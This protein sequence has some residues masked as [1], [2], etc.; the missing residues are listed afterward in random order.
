MSSLRKIER[1]Y[2]AA[3]LATVTALLDRLTDEDVMMR[4]NLEARRD[5]LRRELEAFGDLHEPAASAALFFGGRPVAGALGIESEFG[6]NAVAMFQD[7]VSKIFAQHEPGGLGQRGVVANKAATRLHITNVVRGSFGFLLEEIDPQG[8]LVDTPLREAVEDASK[9][10]GAF[11]EDDEERFQAEVE[12]ADPRVLNTAR[13][14][15]EL[16]RDDEATFK[17]VVGHSEK[18]FN[19][20][21]VAR[22]SERAVGT[23]VEDEEEFLSGTLAGVLPEGHMFEFRSDGPR[24]VIRGKVDKCIPA[25]ELAEY[26]HRWVGVR[27]RAVVRVRR[28]LRNGELARESFTLIRIEDAGPP[29]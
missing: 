20:D 24:G 6:G 26:H 17:L 10:L 18:S 22:A 11:G 13:E 5:E 14:F 16:L 8:A 23:A 25:G 15:F 27:S 19:P 12:N 29:A 3:D 2:V 4:F 9:L 28:V 1:D 21:A 7:L